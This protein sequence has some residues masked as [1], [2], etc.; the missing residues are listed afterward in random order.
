MLRCVAKIFIFER[1]IIRALAVYYLLLTL[2]TPWFAIYIRL[3]YSG[4]FPKG[5]KNS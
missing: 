2:I 4:K 3:Q 5:A 1:R